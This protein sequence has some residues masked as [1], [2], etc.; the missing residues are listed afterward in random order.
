MRCDVIFAFAVAISPYF[1]AA[2]ISGE[3]GQFGVSPAHLQSGF[4]DVLKDLD[5]GFMA[6]GEA[7]MAVSASSAM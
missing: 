6:V 7:D 3:V 2:G 1:W 4:S 5:V